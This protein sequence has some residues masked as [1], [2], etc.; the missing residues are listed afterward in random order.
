MDIE[1]VLNSLPSMRSFI[2][3]VA[4]G[5]RGRVTLVLIP[6]IVSRDMVSRLI[7]N[8]LSALNLETRGLS[9]LGNGRPA[10]AVAEA[11][12][13]SWQ[14]PSAPRSAANLMRCEGMP[15]VV[16]AHRVP[17]SGAARRG[18]W[19]EFIEDWARESV[20]LADEGEISPG[21]CVVAKL[22]DFDFAIPDS[23]A[24]LT[25]L[26]WWGMSSE[27]ETRL[28]CRLANLEYGGADALAL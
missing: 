8:R 7:L 3:R 15:S 26:W 22:R 4:N 21:L 23:Q 10:T 17:N 27:L 12:N 9:S 16:Y 28:A 18:E 6:N 25:L 2:D 1:S 11:L 14:S 20:N 13:V 24:G 5:A 19:R